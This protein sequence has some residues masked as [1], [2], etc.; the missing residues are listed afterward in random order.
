MRDGYLEYLNNL[1]R[2]V[3][4]DDRQIRKE[5]EEDRNRLEYLSKILTE[6]R[7]KGL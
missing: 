3:N 4:T 2:Q 7:K 5:L 6:L 1:E